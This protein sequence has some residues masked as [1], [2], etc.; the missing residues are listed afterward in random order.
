[1]ERYNEINVLFCF[2]PVNATSIQQP[3]DQGVIS[4]FKLYLKNTFHKVTAA[5]ID[6]ES[7]DGSGQR[8]LKTFWKKKSFY[9]ALIKFV[10]HGRM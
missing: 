9:M 5:T 7:S 1:M 2:M 4:T 6:T 3:M 10:I 8:K